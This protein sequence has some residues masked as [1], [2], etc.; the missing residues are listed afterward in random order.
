[1]MN[2]LYIVACTALMVIGLAAH[3]TKKWTD[4]NDD[5]AAQKRQ[6][7]SF[8]LWLTAIAPGK[9][10]TSVLLAIAIYIIYL[11]Q[12]WLDPVSAFLSGIASNSM[13][14]NL[15]KTKK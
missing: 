7:V 9:T 12:G 2:T 14:D 13:A 11:M 15:I 4:H 1:M 5:L 6:R 3:I 10:I 8:G